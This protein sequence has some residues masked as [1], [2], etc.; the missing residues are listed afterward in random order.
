[1]D[2]SGLRQMAPVNGTFSA[3][4]GTINCGN[5]RIVNMQVVMDTN[6]TYEVTVRATTDASGTVSKNSMAACI[7]DGGAWETIRPSGAGGSDWY[8]A[9]KTYNGASAATGTSSND[10][11][12]VERYG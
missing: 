10:K 5:A 4:S 9:Y 12:C 3:V 7:S 1:M 11:Y 8:I 6:S 2:T